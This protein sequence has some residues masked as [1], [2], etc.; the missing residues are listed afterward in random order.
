MKFRSDVAGTVTGVRFYKGSSNTGTHT[1][2]LWSAS[3]TLLA[4]VTFSGET[5][6]GWQQA[7]FSSPVSITANTTYVVSYQAPNGFYSA[8][9]GYFSSAADNVPLHGL[10]SGTDGANGVYNYGATA[11]PTSSYN[12]T[13]YW[14]DVIFSQQ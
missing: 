11:F 2:H 4:S 10:A 14:V 9:S 7:S 5:A 8:N 12:N 1:G 6:S 3:G 13:N